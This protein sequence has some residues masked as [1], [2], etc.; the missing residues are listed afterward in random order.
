MAA[1]YPLITLES[2]WPSR[3]SLKRGF[4]T[5]SL[6]AMRPQPAHGAATVRPISHLQQDLLSCLPD[7]QAS[8]ARSNFSIKIIQLEGSN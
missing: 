8:R 7:L 5:E 6:Q 2:L 1:L 4:C 3:M